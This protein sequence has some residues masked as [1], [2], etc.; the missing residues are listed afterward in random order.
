MN[1]R[2]SKEPQ[3]AGEV[4]SREAKPKLK[5]YTTPVGNHFSDAFGY[6]NGFFNS[7]APFSTLLDECKLMDEKTIIDLIKDFK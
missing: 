1:L 5:F 3:K 6:W 4:T 7:K 2:D